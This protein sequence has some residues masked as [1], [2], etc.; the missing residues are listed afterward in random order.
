MRMTFALRPLLTLVLVLIVALTSA[1]TA[2][3]RAEARGAV[4]V[5]IC[6]D[7][8]T[9]TILLDATGKPV[10]KR[11]GCPDCVLGGFGL[12]GGAVPVAAP[13]LGR[14]RGVRPGRGRHAAP[15]PVPALLARG[16]PGLV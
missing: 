16:P 15:R 14:R 3:G 8:A 12:A 7:G 4:G 11:H 10:A 6:A 1:H 5:L 9:V 2:V 13:A